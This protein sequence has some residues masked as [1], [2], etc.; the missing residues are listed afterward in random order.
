MELVILGLIVFFVYLFI[1]LLANLGAWM[2]RDAISGVPA[3]CRARIMD[4]TK[5][6]GSP[7]RPP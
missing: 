4:G 2:S 6:G 1:R 7:T 3:T 5:A